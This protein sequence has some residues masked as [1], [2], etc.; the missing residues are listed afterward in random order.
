MLD[1]THWP[2]RLRERLAGAPGTPT[3]GGARWASAALA[4]F[5]AAA[6]LVTAAPLWSTL[7]RVDWPQ[8]LAWLNGLFPPV[9]WPAFLGELNAQLAPLRS[10]NSY[11]LFAVMT[12]ER[13]EIVVEGS[14]DGET[15]KPYEFRWKPGD[16]QAR[17]RWVAPHQ[18]RLDWQMWFA[19][20]GTPRENAWFIR[21]L[22]R[23]L[24]G[25]P[26]VL[27]LLK[28]N[29]F[30]DAPPRAIR[31]VLYDYHFTRSGEGPAWWRREEKG[32]YCPPLSRRQTPGRAE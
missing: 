9:R 10:F 24:D 8:P 17:P 27:A 32:L 1:D 4:P 6:V 11:G 3:C 2:A 5:A 21:F 12:T 23:L 29:P 31:A 14:D 7:S 26:E 30:P 19:A 15:W 22:G 13:P 28:T 16:L 18:P 25:T 20:L